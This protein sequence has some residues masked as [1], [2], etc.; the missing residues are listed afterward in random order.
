MI[1]RKLSKKLL[2]LIEN[3]DVF[4]NVIILEGARQVGKTTLV[5]ET[6]NENA[7]LF[8]EINLEEKKSLSEKI[9]QCKNFD[10]F[11]EL[12]GIETNFKI[13]GNEILFIDEA[14]ESRQL[15]RF[16]RFMKEGWR[17][18]QVILSGSSMARLF[19]D[20]VR[21]PVGRV[22]FLH[23]NSLAFTEFL[24]AADDIL[25]RSLDR[26]IKEKKISKFAHA[27]LINRLEQ[28]M[29]VGG[30]PE[31]VTTYLSNGDWLKLRNDLL[32]G[33]Y[34]DFKRVFGEER[35]PY[36]IASLRAVADL[37]GQPFKNSHV[38]RIIDGGRNDRIVE[39]LSQLETWKMIFKIQQKGP[40]PTTA[41]H[42]K[43]Y[44]FDLGVAKT[45]RESAMPDISLK[46][47]LASVQ[48]SP[49]GGMIENLTMLSLI[50][51]NPEL[52]GWKKASSGS[53]VDFI[54]QWNGKVIPFECKSALAI[55][56]SHL[57]G[58]LDYMDAYDLAL[59]AIVSLA[60]L[61]LRKLSRNR[62]VLILPLYLI[63]YWKEMINGI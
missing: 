43:R 59:G 52:C 28:Y 37:L 25:N 27:A 10:D 48:R 58:V 39:S 8:K 34:N 12:I 16:V 22:T 38:S 51:D 5:R 32:F 60:P 24:S 19:R 9:D 57:G 55:K 6:L 42:P 29:T 61:E 44:L 11:T 20:D 13:G 3:K 45:L 26:A 36:F 23:L 49:L 62:S 53:E 31:V 2:Q 17:S 41:F 21:F 47:T 56:N 40:S 14:Q 35:Q 33:Y 46:G 18:T 63:E 15:G 50:E 54:V 1:P 30:L 7:T 4:N